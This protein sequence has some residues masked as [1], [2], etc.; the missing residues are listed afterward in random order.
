[1]DDRTCPVCGMNVADG[2]SFTTEYDAQTYN[3]C[4]A[5]CRDLFAK[6]PGSY[7]LSVRI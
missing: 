6:D 4:S 7:D 5:E 3:F 2:G 1:M